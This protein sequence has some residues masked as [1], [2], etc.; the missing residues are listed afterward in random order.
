MSKYDEF[1]RKGLFTDFEIDFGEGNI[2]KCH[3]VVLA[4]HSNYFRAFNGNIVH[5]EKEIMDIFLN[6]IDFIYTGKLNIESESIIRYLHVSKRFDFGSLLAILNNKLL[7]MVKINNVMSFVHDMCEYDMFDE[8]SQFI[9]L[10]SI[11]IDKKDI[12]HMKEYYDSMYPLLFYRVIKDMNMPEA[13][14]IEYLESYTKHR[15]YL[16]DVE[17]EHFTS[18]ID[19]DKPD[20]YLIAVNFDCLW[21]TDNYY[22]RFLNMIMNNRRNS[23]QRLAS[24]QVDQPVVSR[25]YFFSWLTQIAQSTSIVDYP[26]VNSIEMITTLGGLCSS[27]NP[28]PYNLI[29]V[30][31]L[32]SLNES[33]SNSSY[34]GPENAVYQNPQ[35]FHGCSQ[36]MT[37]P[38]ILIDFG[39]H[40]KFCPKTVM[41]NCKIQKANGSNHFY[42]NKVGIYSGRDYHHKVLI[43]EGSPKSPI[44]CTKDITEQG[45]IVELLESSKN[46]SSSLRIKSIGAYG[47]FNM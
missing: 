10:I 17:K 19:L 44:N 29:S 16:N 2:K 45:I 18:L 32:N 33:P 25:W 40:S 43:G 21:M 30:K 14:L 31:A 9:P 42:P 13:K 38:W 6:I 35:Y 27:F 41:V 26:L 15:G 39:P 47:Y 1:Y 46:G 28:I 4:F 7:Q 34:F 37:K 3:K 20:S 23:I 11:S 22:L 12:K 5:I 24:K 36:G 8:A